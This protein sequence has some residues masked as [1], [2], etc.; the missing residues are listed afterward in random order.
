MSRSF[1][2]IIKDAPAATGVHVTSAIGNS[3]KQ[4]TKLKSFKDLAGA[5]KVEDLHQVDAAV[6]HAQ[7]SEQFVRIA[8]VDEGLG[9]VFGWGIVCKVNGED[10]YDLNIDFAGPHA[11]E[12][13][14][15]HITEGAM[16]KAA[17]DFMGTDRPGNELHDGPDSGHYV[18]TF[19]LTTDIAKAM[20]IETKQTGLMVI[21]KPTPEVLKKFA[22]GTYKGFSIEGRRGKSEEHE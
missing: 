11:G 8:K 2:E 3:G 22:D 10:Y 6:K 13:V 19:P 14:P 9:L 15:E 21:Y 20:G 1:A 18:S 12:R 5:V 7:P 17:V 4:K 16:L